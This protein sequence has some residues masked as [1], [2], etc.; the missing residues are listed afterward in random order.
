MPTFIS[1]SDDWTARRRHGRPDKDAEGGYRFHQW[2]LNDEGIFVNGEDGVRRTRGEPKTMRHIVEVLHKEIFAAS[3]VSGIGEQLLAAVIAT[4]SGGK[5]DAER[6]EKHLNDYSI[7][8]MQTLTATAKQ[9]MRLDGDLPRLSAEPVPSGG[10]LD[11]WRGFL[12][13][14]ANSIA[15]GAGYLRHQN[16]TLEL[17]SDP[18]LLYCSY[19]AGSVR[20]SSKNAW[21]IVSYGSALDHFSRWYGD[22]CNVYGVCE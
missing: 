21:G 20:P 3:G 16:R 17:R 12:R 4:E 6:F 7:G 8:L 13:E 18:I 5:F 1:D 15:L 10:S 14:P 22:A 19:N 2:Q 11:T 9:V